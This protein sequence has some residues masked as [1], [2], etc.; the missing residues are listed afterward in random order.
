MNTK[1]SRPLKITNT[2]KLTNNHEEKRVK[3]A[4]FISDYQINVDNFFFKCRVVLFPK[5]NKLNN[6]IRYT[7]DEK[8]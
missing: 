1:F 2:F 6:I 7:K 5:L 3:F 4:N 8:K